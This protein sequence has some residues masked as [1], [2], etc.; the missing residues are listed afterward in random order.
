MGIDVFPFA[1]GQLQRDMHK[2][3]V[4]MSDNQSCFSRHPRVDSIPTEKA[5]E[6]AVIGIGW[7]TSDNVAGIDIF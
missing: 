4:P 2:M 6:D 1:G 3:I 5:A 7:K